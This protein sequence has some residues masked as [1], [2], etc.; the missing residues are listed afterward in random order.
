MSG[1]G[2]GEEEEEEVVEWRASDNNPGAL[3]G[4]ERHTNVQTHI[5]IIMYTC[6]TY[7][8][9]YIHAHIYTHTYTHYYYYLLQ[10]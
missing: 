2:G 5:H 3:G 4:W 6:H 1:D 9:T 10:N 7:I 8:H